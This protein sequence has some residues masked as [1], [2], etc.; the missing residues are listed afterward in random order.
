MRLNCMEEKGYFVIDRYFDGL[1]RAAP[2]DYQG[3]IVM[4]VDKP[5]GWTSADVVRKIKFLA[6]KYFHRKNIKVGHAGTLDPLATGLLLVC[7]GKATKVAERLQGEKKEYIA[8]IRLGATTP[9]FDLEK[10]VDATY[11]FEHITLEMVK[12]K[13][14]MLVGKQMQV[15]PL[16]SAKYVDGVRAY[17]KARAGE[18]VELKAAEITIYQIEA[19]A[20]ELPD[21]TV[22]ISCSKGTYVRAL[23]RDIGV[24]LGSGAHLTGLVRSASGG[25]R[26][27]NALSMEQV[28]KIFK[29]NQQ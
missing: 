14:G 15:P 9:S 23:A 11:P 26:L 13:L 10:E 1:L 24:M 19:T 6:Q 17:E 18:E 22:R 16:F 25:F 29:N 20:F 5:Y 7:M 21:L 27:E 2:E 28:S 3:G 4:P 12:E 8:K